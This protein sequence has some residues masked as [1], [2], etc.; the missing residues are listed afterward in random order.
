MNIL[1]VDREREDAMTAKIDAYDDFATTYS[2]MVNRRE[3]VGIENEPIMPHFLSLL[4]DIAGLT[5]LDAGCGQG[6][7][8][9]ILARRGAHVTG[10]DISPNLIQIA[11]EQDLSHQI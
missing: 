2:D 7:L 6:Y 4:G 1:Y 5:V 10:M 8:S 3:Q 11:R 9:R